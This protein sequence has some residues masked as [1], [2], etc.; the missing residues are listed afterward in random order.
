MTT[1]DWDE[2]KRL[3]AD[4]QKAQLSN[5][6]QKL[7]ER[8]CV[9]IIMKLTEDK[10]LNVI[11]T[12]DGKEY[13]TPQHLAQEIKD[14]LF[15]HGGRI[16]LAQ[17]AKILNVDLSQIS[18]A[19][20]EIEKHDRG[21]KIL[22]GQLID[23]TYMNKISEEIN[24]KLNQN[25]FINV[26]DLTLHYD[27]PAD[28]IQST[29]EK[30]LGKTIFGKQDS[31]DPK[32][33]YNQE[34]IARNEAK[35]RGA[36]SA[37]TRPTPISA[38]LGQCAVPERIFFSILENLQDKKQIPGVVSGKQ[39]SNSIYVPTIYSK[40][41]SEWVDGFYRQNGYLEY[42]AM[43]RLGISDPKNFVKRHFPDENLIYLDSVA[44]GSIIIDQVNANIEEVV[45]TGSFTDIYSLLPSVFSPCDAELLLKESSSKMKSFIHIFSSTMIVSD[46]YLQKIQKNLEVLCDNKAKE[47]VESGKW[48]QSVV[49][50]KIKSKAMDIIDTKADRKSERRKKAI[51]GK[52]GGG[53]QGRETKTKSTKKKYQ[54]NKHQ[55]IESDEENPEKVNSKFDLINIDDLKIELSKDENLRDMEELIDELAIHFLKGLNKTAASI[56]EQLSQ[57]H[58]TTNLSEV[59][60]KLNSFVTTIRVYERGIKCLEK[61]IQEPMV[62]YLL[63]T[64][65]VD[66]VTEI[67]KLSAQQNV[68]QC[69]Q[70]LSTEVRHKMLLEL[71]KD[72]RE[73]LSGLHKVVGGNSVENF[74]N[75]V[76]PAMAACCLVLKKYDKKKDRAIVVGHREAMLEQLNCTQDP[77]LALHLT[78]AIL[79]I[80]TTQNALHMSGRHVSTI[81]TFLRPL[82]IEATGVTLFKYHDL[83]L[84]FLSTSDQD[85]K[86]SLQNELE[87]N[88]AQIKI[89]ANDY[90]KQIKDDKVQDF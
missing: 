56:A 69:P 74:I 70:N 65:G 15:V 59:E 73:P 29:I 75:S 8:N 77:A 27:L 28:F 39:G 30:E 22:L 12:N 86:R 71:P 54:Q 14:E 66:F 45:A 67:F 53:S 63:K 84:Q 1:A 62:K 60:E 19:S 26:V 89:I 52:T 55:D 78:T 88:L 72:V 81:L 4:F 31:Q 21:I 5:A 23:K 82:L 20:A 40:G 7:S 37:L 85:V 2:V 11:F 58:K 44:V 48:L 9:E 43:S 46:A 87:E 24:D 64:L 6:L 80:A 51:G 49:E 10:L 35:I 38:I 83:V 57:K 32:I 50:N 79:Y 18:K 3:A 41:Q 13:V 47:A 34:Y 68:I 42:D 76:E 90:K 61:S 16:D 36:L 17:L 33:I 25:G